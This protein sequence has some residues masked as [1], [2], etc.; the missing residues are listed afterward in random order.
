MGLTRG[1]GSNTVPKSGKVDLYHDFTNFFRGAPRANG[2][3]F[4]HTAS[5]ENPLNRPTR[6]I[7]LRPEWL[8]NGREKGVLFCRSVGV[9]PPF[10]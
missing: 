10:S 5:G 4:P 2:C 7:P 1:N 9:S 6:L 8:A 3:E